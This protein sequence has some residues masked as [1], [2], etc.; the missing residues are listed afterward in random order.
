MNMLAEVF[1]KPSETDMLFILFMHHLGRKEPFLIVAF[2][3]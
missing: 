3:S 2:I 1:Y